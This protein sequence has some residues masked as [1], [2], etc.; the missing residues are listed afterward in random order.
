MA[1]LGVAALALVGWLW[2]R[3]HL[4]RDAGR[5]LAL[6]GGAALATVLASKGSWVAAAAVASATIALGLA[7]LLRRTTQVRPLDEIEARQVLGVS[8]DANEAAILEAHRRRIAEV[9]P[10]KGGS[11]DEAR[12]VNAARDLLLARRRRHR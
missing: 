7:G 2:W 11:A 12:R 8:L 1:L 10:D 5:K 4:S 3:G 6:V 9:H